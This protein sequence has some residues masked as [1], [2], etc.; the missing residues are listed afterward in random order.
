MNLETLCLLQTAPGLRTGAG[1]LK[2][3][4][5]SSDWRKLQTMKVSGTADPK[6]P[7]IG[8]W[9]TIKKGIY[10]GDAGFVLGVKSWGGVSVLLIPRLPLYPDDVKASK[11]KRAKTQV[12]QDPKLFDAVWAERNWLQPDEQGTSR[13]DQ[14]Q[15]LTKRGNETYLF[16][17]NVY[18]YGLLRKS[19]DLRSISPPLSA[20]PSKCATLFHASNHPALR[21][22]TFPRPIE[23]TFVEGDR[24]VAKTA[25]EDSSTTSKGMLVAIHPHYAEV[26]LDAGF[27]HIVNIPWCN[28]HKDFQISDH[29]RVTSGLIQG[30]TGWITE[31]EES[32]LT[33][34]IIPD[35]RE[36]FRAL[37]EVE[38]L[39]Q[40]QTIAA[41]KYL[42]HPAENP[43]LELPNPLPNLVK[44]P[45]LSHLVNLEHIG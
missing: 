20:L 19:Y 27:E 36:A 37:R 9:V 41:N 33:A 44:Q 15:H 34:T 42:L 16:L 18:E 22:A 6:P 14:P 13:N 28:L 23:W 24:V 12:L 31:I 32:G 1:I 3:Q 29:V 11:R 40:S 10:H 25:S 7:A 5:S 30:T 35:S 17:H 39:A 8:S 38:P 26:S 4:I 43:A 2:H 21:K 45:T